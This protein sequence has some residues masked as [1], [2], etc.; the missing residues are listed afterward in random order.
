MSYSN[1]TF[2]KL[3]SVYRIEQDS[4]TQNLFGALKN[5]SVAPSDRLLADLTEGKT[6]PLLT[7]KAKSEIL[8]MPILREL[9]RNNPHITIFSGF[10]LHVKGHRALTGNPDFLLSAKPNLVEI[11]APVLCLFESKNKSVEEG[12][13]QCAAEMYAA[14]LFNQQSGESY[15][16]IYGVVTNAFDWVFLKLEGNTVYID[17]ERYYLNELPKLLGILQWILQEYKK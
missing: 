6:M 10:A 7:E 14:R 8:I 12:Y 17:I 4:S 3:K 2:A 16:T 15:E 9:K 13:A 5:L 11:E 1:F